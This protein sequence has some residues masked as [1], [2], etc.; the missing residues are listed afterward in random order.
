MG[1]FAPSRS[2]V[3]ALAAAGLRAVGRWPGGRGRFRRRRIA[4]LVGARPRQR[5]LAPP[6]PD[7]RRGAVAVHG[8]FHPAHARVRLARAGGVG[9]PLVDERELPDLVEGSPPPADFDLVPRREHVEATGPPAP[10]DLALAADGV[11]AVHDDQGAEPLVAA[12]RQAQRIGAPFAGLEVE[13][14]RPVRRAVEGNGLAGDL[15][16]DVD[17]GS[18]VGKGSGA[19]QDGQGQ[20]GCAHVRP[21][22]GGGTGEAPGIFPGRLGSVTSRTRPSGP[23]PGG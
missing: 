22:F 10:H 1:R 9:R 4:R 20:Q 6:S 2:R 21:P 23:R 13:T 8:H 11:Q 14:A 7:V 5:A 15:D 16:R 17:E 12:V 3:A 19:G 18:G